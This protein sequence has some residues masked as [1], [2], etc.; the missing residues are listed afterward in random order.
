M[1]FPNHVDH[2]DAALIAPAT[3]AAGLDGLYAEADMRRSL[4]E[5][6]LGAHARRLLPVAGDSASAAR[7]PAVARLNWRCEHA[8]Q[9]ERP[10]SA[11]REEPHRADVGQVAVALR[12]VDAVAD[13]EL[14]GDLE[15]D[16]VRP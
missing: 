13:D 15:A 6:G 3:I 12:V 5:R 11:F 10:C 16:P 1:T 7:P 4:A 8:R 14:V 2:T 9:G